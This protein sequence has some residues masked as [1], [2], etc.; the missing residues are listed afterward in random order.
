M[1]LRL[2]APV[3]DWRAFW[4]EVGIIVLGIQIVSVCAPRPSR[5]Q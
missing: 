5:T 4:S 2:F 1:R 3:H